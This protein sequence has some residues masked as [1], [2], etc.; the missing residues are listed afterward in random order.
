MKIFTQILACLLLVACSGE[1]KLSVIGTR[2]GE[3]ITIKP[4]EVKDTVDLYLS[5]LVDDIEI[6]RLETTKGALVKPAPAYVS[7]NYVLTGIAEMKLFERKTGKYIGNVGHN[8][9]GPGEYLSGI[10]CAQIDEKARNIYML[11]YSGTGEP[12]QILVYDL[13]G[14]WRS[15]DIPL[16]SF[17]PKGTFHIDTKNNRLRIAVLPFKGKCEYVAWE[18]DLEGNMING[19]KAK[20]LDVFPRILKRSKLDEKQFNSP[21]S[22]LQYS[23]DARY[24]VSL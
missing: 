17:S 18:Q 12:Q 8:G 6:V 13:N 15:K 2:N 20:H 10:Y 1:Q 14:K 11:S 5:D 24:V 21:F 22:S 16:A 19:V 7:D 9:R 4:H 3:L 23:T